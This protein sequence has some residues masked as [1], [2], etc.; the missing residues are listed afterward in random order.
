MAVIRFLSNEMKGTIGKL[1]KDLGWDTARQKGFNKRVC[2]R[3]V[4][5]T[6]IDGSKIMQGQQAML[7]S[8]VRPHYA[9]FTGLVSRLRDGADVLTPWERRFLKDIVRKLGGRSITPRLIKKVREI[10]HKHDIECGFP[11]FRELAKAADLR[12]D[13]KSPQSPLTKGGRGRKGG[14][15]YAART[16]N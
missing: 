4:P 3:E 11:S 8:R 9:A 15:R 2:G 12:R 5:L 16:R 6:T 10:A 7:M 14:E 1:S 13:E